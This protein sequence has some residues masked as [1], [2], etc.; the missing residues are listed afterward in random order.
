MMVRVMNE[1][2]Q[3]GMRGM[4]FQ[5]DSELVGRAMELIGPA[6]RIALLAHEHPDGDCL[7]SA[8]GMAQLLCQLGKECVAVCADPVPRA[9][10]FLPGAERLQ[11][12]LGDEDFDLVIALDAN[13]MERF[14]GLYEKHQHFLGTIPVINIDHHMNSDG[15]GQVNIIDTTAAATAELLALFAQQLGW[16]VHEEAALCFLTG[17]ITDT[18]SFQY[19]NTTPRALEVAAMLLRHGAVPET[20]AQPVYRVRPLAQARFQ[21][22]VMDKAKTAC[23]GRL[24]WSYATGEMLREAGATPEMDDGF[25]G[26]LRD[27]EGVEMAVF[28][29]SYDDPAITRLSMRC[30]APYNAAE[31]CQRLANGG[32]H[33]RAAGGTLHLPVEEAME[34]VMPELEREIETAHGR[35]SQHS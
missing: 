11:H 22:W 17:I 14:G 21:A 10:A 35:D 25:S 13:E 32:G 19:S 4:D 6:R 5:L 34:F 12:S 28:F 31:I 30:A 2:T 16:P 7:G 9:L 3:Q 15:C 1:V 33:A 24:I 27:I 8:L 23:G 20:V 26:M 18:G 29:K